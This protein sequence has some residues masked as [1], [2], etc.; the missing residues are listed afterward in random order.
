MGRAFG[1]P[2]RSSSIAG[3]V[4]NSVTGAPLHRATVEI[5]LEGR[6]D[7]RGQ[8]GTEGDGQF[9]LRALPAGRYRISVSRPGYA[10]MNYGARRPNAPGQIV[11]L[12]ANENKSGLVVRMNLL[13]AVS[14][15]IARL[16]PSTV[17]AYVQATPLHFTPGTPGLAQI[18]SGTVDKDGAYRVYNLLPGRYLIAVT[19]SQRQPPPSMP[20]GTR[21]DSNTRMSTFYPSTLNQDEAQIVDVAPGADV[22]GIDIAVRPMELSTL[23]VRVQWPDGVVIEKPTTASIPTVLP[24]SIRSAASR[25]GMSAASLSFQVGDTRP[26]YSSLVPGRYSVGGTVDLLGRCYAASREV[27]LSGGPADAVLLLEPCVDLKGRIVISGVGSAPPANLRVELR[28]HHEQFLLHDRGNVQPDGVFVIRAIPPGLWDVTVSPLPAASYLK[29][30]TL[31]SLD[32]LNRPMPITSSTAVPLQIVVGAR[33]AELRGHV[34]R[35]IA[36]TVL[37]APEGD[38]AAIPSRYA[39]TAVD[40][41][42]DFR[43]LGLYPGTYRIYAFE[44]LE[45]QAWVDPDFLPQYQDLGALVQLHEGSAPALSL[46]TIPG[47][48]PRSKGGAR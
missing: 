44:D 47:T 3:R 42:G 22:A 16:P 11:T 34:E 4:V 21:F 2:E 5:S 40:E 39:T 17:T 35:G 6:D 20:A 41:N 25:S 31:G 27:D 36:T 33:G 32:V 37:A 13:G 38:S 46:K 19:Y 15:T 12:G 26:A 14:G 23:A 10:P 48:R 24:I 43:F 29:A 18:R 1:Q 7:V 30:M 45:P 9:L 8:A 28:S